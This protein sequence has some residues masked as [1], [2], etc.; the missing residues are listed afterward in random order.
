MFSPRCKHEMI[1]KHTFSCIQITT[2]N[3]FF[4]VYSWIIV[5]LVILFIKLTTLN[6]YLNSFTVS[7]FYDILYFVIWWVLIGFRYAY[8]DRLNLIF[9]I[10]YMSYLFYEHRHEYV[11]WHN[12][13]LY[14]Y[15]SSYISIQNEQIHSILVDCARLDFWLNI[16]YSGMDV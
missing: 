5:M 6:F 10:N 12:I 16:L 11:L 1:D 4:C 14:L 3:T 8:I 15:I 7:S 2:Y 13:I 9:K